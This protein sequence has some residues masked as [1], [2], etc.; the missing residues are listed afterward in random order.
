VDLGRKRIGLAISDASRT[1]ARPLRTIVDA[2]SAVPSILAGLFVYAASSR[3]C[4]NSSR[5]LPRRWR[6]RC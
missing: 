3:V 4:T 6:S 1:L 5:G 2:M